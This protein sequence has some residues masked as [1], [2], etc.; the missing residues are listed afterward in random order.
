MI[1]IQL[2]KKYIELKRKGYDKDRRY[3]EYAICHLITFEDYE[4]YIDKRILK[5]GN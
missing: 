3:M 4:K 5:G 1:K 2:L